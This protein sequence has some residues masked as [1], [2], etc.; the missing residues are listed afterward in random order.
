MVGSVY[1]AK[2][3]EAR[4]AYDKH[5]GEYEKK[6]DQQIALSSAVDLVLQSLSFTTKQEY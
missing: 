5:K 2:A 3:V 4:E 1:T 6:H